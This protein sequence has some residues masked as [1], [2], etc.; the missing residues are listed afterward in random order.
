MR[1]DG[2]EPAELVALAERLGAW[3]VSDLHLLGLED[4]VREVDA[5]VLQKLASRWTHR[6]L[7]PSE[8]RFQHARIG[9]AYV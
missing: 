5:L 4:L 7:R 3:K 1:L 8:L 2:V 6:G 9:G